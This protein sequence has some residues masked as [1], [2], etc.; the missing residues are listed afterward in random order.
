MLIGGLPAASFIFSASL[1]A[2]HD[3]IPIFGPSFAP[4]HIAPAHGAGLAGEALFVAFERSLH[5]AI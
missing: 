1:R 4:G 5:G 2:I 3:L